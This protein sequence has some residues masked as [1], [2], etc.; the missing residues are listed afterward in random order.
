MGHRYTGGD[1]W[2]PPYWLWSWRWTGPPIIKQKH[3]AAAATKAGDA[4]A[5]KE[6]DPTKEVRYIQVIDDC[7][8]VDFGIE[9]DLVPKVT[10]VIVI[11]PDGTENTKVYYQCRVFPCTH[12]GQNHV[13]MMNHVR[14]CLNIKLQCFLCTYSADSSKSVNTH[15]K[16]EHPTATTMKMELGEVEQK[17]AEEV[18]TT[19]ARSQQ[20][21]H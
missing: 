9:P 6:H 12:W 21:Q 11:A 15:I 13:L 8:P 5:K 20:S 4:A 3:T 16:K 17:E 14:C 7:T 2:W 1:F 19:I 10:D 18:V